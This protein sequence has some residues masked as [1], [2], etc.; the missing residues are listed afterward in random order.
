MDNCSQCGHLTATL[1]EGCCEICR[2][3]NQRELDLHNA[4]YDWWQS[5]TP[6][7]RDAQIKNAFKL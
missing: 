6:A 3:Q 5:L 2:E 1:N 7:E 4:Q